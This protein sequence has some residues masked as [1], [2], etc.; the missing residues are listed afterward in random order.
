[1]KLRKNIL[2]EYLAE[3]PVPLALERVVEGAI[4]NRYEFC[5]PVLD[6]GCGEGLFA[7]ILFGEQIDTGIDP[8]QKEIERAGELGAYHELL[9]CHGDSVPK[10]DNSFKT[11][12]SNSVLEHIPDLEP[13][14]KEIN[15]LLSPGGRFYMTVPSNY[16]DKYTVINT[17]LSALGLSAAAERY[18]RFFNSFWKHYHFYTLEEW[19]KIAERNGFNIVDAFTYNPRK[20]CL[21][22]DF[23][24]PFALPGFITKKMT[25]RWSLF[26]NTRKF[27]MQHLAFI[28][29]PFLA[30]AEK[31]E[32][33]GL[34]FMVL[35][36]ADNKV[37][38]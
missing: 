2:Q 10:P 17:M 31:C 28:F 12:F 1:M 13:V 20:L 33:G 21:L 37:K 11:I 4:Y 36:K 8:N 29:K 14:L 15:R 7:K 27:L 6:V 26:P 24:V 19:Q 30:Q 35:T 9:I 23:L 22:N 16:F 32:D 18:R 34:V 5:H 38:S 3:A 25:N